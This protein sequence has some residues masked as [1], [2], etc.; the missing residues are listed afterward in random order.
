MV[1]AFR[2]M[3]SYSCLIK[4]MWNLFLFLLRYNVYLYINLDDLYTER[5][6]SSTIFGLS[7]AFL[8]FTHDL[9]RLRHTRMTLAA[10]KILFL[11]SAFLLFKV[12][13]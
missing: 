9:Q 4:P 12:V 2:E 10:V 5:S 6:S 13:Q 1:L 7:C 8:P 3:P 11:A